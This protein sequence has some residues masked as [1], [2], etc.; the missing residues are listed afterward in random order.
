MTRTEEWKAN[1]EARGTTDQL[2][3]LEAARIAWLEWGHPDGVKCPYPKPWVDA[4]P[5]GW[6]GQKVD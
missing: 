3:A 2:V 6:H 5:E 4:F 1:K